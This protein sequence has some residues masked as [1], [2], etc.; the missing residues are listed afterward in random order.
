M[1]VVALVDEA[2]AA[3]ES[4]PAE[5]VCARWI[6][7]GREEL[8]EPAD[9]FLFTARENR[10]VG[11]NAEGFGVLRIAA[12]HL[13]GDRERVVELAGLAV[14]LGERNGVPRIIGVGANQILPLALRFGEIPGAA[15]VLG[16]LFAHDV[17][18]RMAVEVWLAG[19]HSL[20]IAVIAGIRATEAEHGAAVIGLGREATLVVARR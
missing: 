14:R 7:L 9:R 18:V 1:V 17:V 20:R 15:R 13:T 3:T 16:E 19:R 12:D 8:L 10:V 2:V 5:L 11:E 4:E 6:R